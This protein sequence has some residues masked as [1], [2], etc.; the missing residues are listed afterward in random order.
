LGGLHDLKRETREKRTLSSSTSKNYYFQW[1]RLRTGT[2]GGG[3]KGAVEAIDPYLTGLTQHCVT[4]FALSPQMRDM[5]VH[6]IAKGC[7][8][9]AK[10]LSDLALQGLS[11]RCPVKLNNTVPVEFKPASCAT[12]AQC[13]EI[14][15]KV[16]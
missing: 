14:F 13:K 8:A 4:H 15:R 5:S 3:C 1:R 16:A 10:A 9:P 7:A 6:I 2:C 12:T 11:A